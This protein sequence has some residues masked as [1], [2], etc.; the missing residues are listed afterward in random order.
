[1]RGFSCYRV[2]KA[3]RSNS[4]VVGLLGGERFLFAWRVLICV[5]L[6]A[7]RSRLAGRNGRPATT[8]VQEDFSWLQDLPRR[9]PVLREQFLV[10][11][12]RGKRVADVGFLDYPLLEM[13]ITGK[14][15]LHAALAEVA[16]SIVGIDSDPR[17]VEWA[18]RAG[19]EAYVADAS[20]TTEIEDLNLEPADVVVAGEVIEHVDA[21]GPFLRAMLRL[22]RPHG[23]LIVTT[24]NAYRALN[25]IVP[26]TG[27]EF[28][29]PEHLAWHSP[30]TLTRL[31]DSNGWEIEAL[32]YYQNRRDDVRLDGGFT[33][34]VRVLLANAARR[35]AT[36]GRRPY[37]C[38]GLI[39]VARPGALREAPSLKRR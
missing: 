36:S 37:W 15:W 10:D 34:A 19:L 39:A 12:C 20:S 29:H 7:T 6:S 24:P 26:L 28:I 1:M 11:S 22:C 35:L 2:K 31:L 25:L 5:G 8:P 33:R 17:G 21:P 38:D 13:R 23:Q 30:H 18:R 9:G 27:K 3:Q 4:E 14:T 16:A 32:I